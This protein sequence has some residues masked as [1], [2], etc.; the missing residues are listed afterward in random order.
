MVALRKVTIMTHSGLSGVCWNWWHVIVYVNE[1]C[2]AKSGDPKKHNVKMTV[3][4][5]LIVDVKVNVMANVHV[6][7]SNDE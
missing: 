5:S 1:M 3:N 7:W 4:G 6:M 2:A